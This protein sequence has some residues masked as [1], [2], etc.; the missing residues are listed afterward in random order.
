MPT[1][2]VPNE[3]S[4]ANPLPTQ[5]RF[6][7]QTGYGNPTMTASY[8]PSV[9]FVPINTNNGWSGQLPFQRTT[10]QN[11]QVAGVQQGHM[12]V[13]FQNQAPVA[14]PMN[15]AQQIGGPQAMVNMLFAR[16]SVP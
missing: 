16:D 4:L 9:G 5:Q 6:M 12:H 8:Q 2:Q 7:P 1:F 10:Q 15:L 11:H 14:Q 13:G 3:S